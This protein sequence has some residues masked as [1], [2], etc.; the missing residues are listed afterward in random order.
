MR[1]TTFASGT[2]A[3]D[4]PVARPAKTYPAKP[5]VFTRFWNTLIAAQEKRARRV[6]GAHLA[7]MDDAQLARLGW[8]K[9]ELSALRKAPA[10]ATMAL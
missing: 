3:L 9:A 8:N 2:V 6:V 7:T 4:T 10:D 1:S 5:G